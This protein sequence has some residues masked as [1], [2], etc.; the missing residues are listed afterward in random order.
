MRDQ[1]FINGRWTAGTG[2]T[3]P[4][5]DPATG[6]I[7]HQV[8]AGGPEDVEAAV[9]AAA[10]AFPSWSRTSGAARAA[11]LD[12]I[13]EGLRAKAEELARLSSRINGKPLAEARVDLADSATTFAYYAGLARKLDDQRN[14]PVELADPGF[15]AVLRREPVG[16]AALITPWNFP[17]VTSAW[18][19]APALAAGCAVVLKPSEITA[20]LDL[21]LGALAQEAGLPPG[22]L[23]ILPGTGDSVGTPLCAHPKI[24]KISFTGSN[25]VGERVMAAAARGTKRVSLELGGKSAIVVFADAD[26]DHAAELAASGIFTNAGQMCSATGRLLVEASVM[27]PLLD[28]LTA[29]ARGL[30]LGPGL[31]PETTMGPLTTRAQRDKVLAAI[32]QGL[33]DGATIVTGGGVPADR[34][35]GWFVEPT[36]L[37]GAPLDSAL[38]REEIF[39]PVLCVQP[40]ADEEE[41]VRLANDS[42]FGLVATVVTGDDARAERVAAALEVG[43]VWIDCPQMVFVEA[44]WGGWRR[45]GVGRELGPWGLAAFQEIKHVVRPRRV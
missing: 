42:D 8:A 44:S 3:L 9:S 33:A 29:L 19:V 13:A 4:V 11:F 37:T 43:V 32:R 28:R 21:E 26:L 34:A 31:E 20:P 10:A 18:K 38:W 35:E 39:G 45:S 16:V 41:A 5:C 40:F 23:N 24:A 14:A 2:G 22:V 1:L 36:I 12:A 15:D 7:I 30:R 25:A 6:Q 17:L 27:Q